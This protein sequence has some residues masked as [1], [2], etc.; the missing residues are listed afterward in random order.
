[1][2]GVQ[3]CALP[4]Y[5][6]R[7]FFG[8]GTSLQELYLQ[9]DKLT[10]E[11]WRILAEAARWSR[12][13]ADVFVDTHWIGGDPA[14][15]EVYGYASW[16]PRQGILMLRNPDDQPR[17]YALDIATAFELPRSAPTAYLLTSPWAEDSAR[18]ARLAQAGIPLPFTLAPFEI[19]VLDAVPRP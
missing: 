11:D 12:A 13:N 17:N 9:P 5:D 3:T 1:M 2:T 19:V 18:P 8:S 7:A 10:P 6:V 14:R 16:S 15:L 4:I